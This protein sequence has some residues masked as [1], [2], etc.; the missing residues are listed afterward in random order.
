MSRDGTA[1][2]SET[3]LLHLLVLL[4]GFNDSCDV[5]RE[6]ELLESLCDVVAS[7]GLLGL[8]FGDL[9]GLGGDEG[10]EFNAALDQQVAGLL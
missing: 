5:V 4:R 1:G 10:D 7:N 3:Y 9:V 8:L 6:A 2:G